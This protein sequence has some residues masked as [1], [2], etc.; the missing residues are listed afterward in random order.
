MEVRLSLQKSNVSALVFHLAGLLA[1]GRARSGVAVEL[2][3]TGADFIFIVILLIKIHTAGYSFAGRKVEGWR[4]KASVR[5]F[6][7]ANWFYQFAATF[8]HSRVASGLKGSVVNFQDISLPYEVGFLCVVCIILH[9]TVAAVVPLPVR[10]CHS[11]SCQPGGF[12][13]WCAV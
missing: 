9:S 7:P 5:H 6:L 8:I 12:L 2:R 10:Q 3:G 4:G 11:F 1:G 13:R